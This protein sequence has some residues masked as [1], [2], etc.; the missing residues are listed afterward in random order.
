M[1]ENSIVMHDGSLSINIGYKLD[2]KS[3][4]LFL[5][6]FEA[7]CEVGEVERLA[8]WA[9]AKGCATAEKLHRKETERKK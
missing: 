9:Y 8:I 5:D 6:L 7:Y 4:K 1:N 3:I 2:S